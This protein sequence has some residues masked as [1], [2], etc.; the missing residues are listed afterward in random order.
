M[1]EQNRTIPSQLP[2]QTMDDL[3][4]APEGYEPEESHIQEE[5]HESPEAAIASSKPSSKDENM[6]R[7]RQQKE[8]AERERDELLNHLKKMQE[9]RQ[10]QKQEEHEAEL[11]PDDLVEWKYVQ[12]KFK[13]LEEKISN[14]YA[15][16]EQYSAESRLK[17]HYPDFD[18]I[19]N[20]E[21]IDMLRSLYPDL[22]S[23]IATS[24]SDLY[25]KGS[26]AYTMIKKLGIVPDENVIQDRQRAQANSAKPRPLSSVNNPQGDPLSR[27]NAFANGLTDELKKALHKEMTEARKKI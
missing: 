19:V 12:K 16:Q 15:Q 21:N 9:P 20:K 27:A 7:L 23:T 10:A 13:N 6:A 22:A 14:Q 18:N 25:A 1:N 17:S 11:G 5:V 8:K 26:S 24:T 4:P 3:P 2:T